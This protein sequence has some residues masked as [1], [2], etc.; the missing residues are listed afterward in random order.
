ML[1]RGLAREAVWREPA[2][3]IVDLSLG[4]LFR[5]RA[6]GSTAYMALF[7]EVAMCYN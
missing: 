7:S 1:V 3:G 2:S 4:T 6:C 5:G